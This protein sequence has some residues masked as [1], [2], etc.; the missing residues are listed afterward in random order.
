MLYRKI[1][2]PENV[3][4]FCSDFLV[5][6]ENVYASE[7]KCILRKLILNIMTSFLF[8]KDYVEKWKRGY[9]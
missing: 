8:S 1:E 3:I 4:E 5:T 2:I 7:R 6:L 9:I